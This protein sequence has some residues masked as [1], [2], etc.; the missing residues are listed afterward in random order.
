MKKITNKTKI[1]TG[2]WEYEIEA[3]L[4]AESNKPG[5]FIILRLHERGERIPLTIADS[6]LEKGTITI[7]AQTAGKTTRQLNE[8]FNTGD[9]VHDLVGP[10]G[11]PSEIENYGDVVTIG[12]GVGIALI[13]P[14]AKALK[15]AG[16]NV[17]SIIGSQSSDKLFY[18]EK[19]GAVSDE[20]I[21]TTDDG[22]EGRKGFTSDA[23][24]EI[25]QE[26]DIDKS[27]AIGP[28]I[29]MKVCS[30]V[31]EKYNTQLIVSLNTIMVDGTGMCGGC[32][33][34]VG[35]EAKFACIDGP[36]FDAK[37]V[38]FE[39]LMQRNQTYTEEEKCALDKYM[40]EEHV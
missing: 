16:N 13:Y 2:M 35:D 14:I 23:F 26:K 27:W 39:I 38:N 37:L 9:S 19:I 34:E 20:L 29:M 1:G 30:E 7:A 22:S 40:E 25:L 36:E 6:N 12:G 17:T 28:V 21:V 33:V 5:Q 8:Q 31:A 32:R 18:Q 24:E 10:L 11:N 3:P 15:G 4:I